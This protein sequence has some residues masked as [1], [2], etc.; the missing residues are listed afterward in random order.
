MKLLLGIFLLLGD[1]DMFSL[2]AALETLDY[3][4]ET[5]FLIFIAKL[6]PPRPFGEYSPLLG[7]FLEKDDEKFKS[8]S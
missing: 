4:E 2:E 6:P 5:E 1:C 7:T 8:W 3:L